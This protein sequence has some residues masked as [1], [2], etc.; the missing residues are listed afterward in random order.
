MSK[1]TAVLLSAAAL[2]LILGSAAAPARAAADAAL[3]AAAT[4]AQPALVESLKD[5]VAIES[6]SGNAEGLARMADYVERRLAAAGARVE[7]PKPAKGTGVLVKG[8]FTGDGTRRVLLIAHMDTVYPAG[9]LDAQPIRLEGN[10]LYGPGIADDKGGIAVILHSLD[11]LKARGWRDYARLTV[12]F[13]G[14]EEVGSTGSGEIIAAAADE[15][16]VVLSCE[17]TAAKAVARSE[18]LLLG[19]SGTATA[20]LSV[21]GRSSHAGA[22]PQLGRN[23]LVELAHQLVQ[24]RDVAAGVPGTQL[25][26]TRAQADGPGNQIPERAA[27]TADVRLTAR[28]GAERL[29]AALRKKVQDSAL[30]PDTKTTV[31]L[32]VG[33]PA[34][35]ANDA[36]RALARR[37][38]A[39]YAELD[40]R[41]LLLVPMTGGATDAA[42]AGR[43]G[44][45]AVVESF[46][47][48]GYGYHARDEY[49]ELDSIVPRLYLMTR[50]LTTL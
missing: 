5:M 20:T 41:P 17:P 40:D 10:R 48:A 42:F 39:I 1:R 15:H 47:L 18:A 16:D 43:S 29:L 30:V 12:L 35:V 36:G 8:S 4:A 22:A 49:V 27:A 26:W 38:Q 31:T 45:A 24:T 44:R 6:G 25:N 13:N 11:I 14:D 37:A 46:G 28:D 19:A 34:F 2:A 32:E 23:A 50:L 7:R 9:T 21:E 33:R 3:L